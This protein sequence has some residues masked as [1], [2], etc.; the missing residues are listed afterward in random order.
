MLVYQKVNHHHHEKGKDSVFIRVFCESQFEIRVCH[1]LRNH[2]FCE[3]VR[4]SWIAKRQST[5]GPLQDTAVVAWQFWIHMTLSLQK[6]G[7]K[8]G[9]VNSIF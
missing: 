1:I 6:S 8:Y 4:R 9:H 7:E 3:T 5:D 2:G